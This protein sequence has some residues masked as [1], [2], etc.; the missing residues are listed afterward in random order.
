VT[1]S[2]AWTPSPRLRR[3][4]RRRTL[5]R[6]AV[7]VGAAA[8]IFAVGVALG[9]VLD[10]NPDASGSPTTTSIRTLGPLPLTQQSTVTVTVTGP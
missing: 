1:T 10:D 9:E 6:W 8:V 3:K 7:R 2:P 5:V 4:R